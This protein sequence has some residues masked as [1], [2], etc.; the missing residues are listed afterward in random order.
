LVRT[1]GWAFRETWRTMVKELAPQSPDGDYMRPASSIVARKDG[2]LPMLELQDDGH[3]VYIGNTC[4]WCHRVQLAVTLARIPADVVAMV[5]LADDPQRAS[6]GGWAFNPAKGIVDPVFDAADLREVY[7]KASGGRYTGRCTAPL[8]VD[9]INRSAVSNDN[10]EIVRMVTEA[11]LNKKWANKMVDLRPAEL[12]KDIEK[13][14]RWTYNMI[15]N[16]VYRAGFATQQGAFERAAADVAEGLDRLEKLL[17]KQRFLCG[18]KV[19]EADAMLL[20]CALRFDVVYAFLFLRGSCGLWRERPSLKRWL[21]DCWS[22]PGVRGTIDLRACQESY[23]RTLFPLNASQIIPP[24][25]TP[26]KLQPFEGVEEL[27]SEQAEALF[28]WQESPEVVV[29]SA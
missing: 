15:S 7:D 17:D 1:A 14:I 12:G 29:D 10:I 5:E 26:P 25:N 27:T 9:R 23:Y 11:A 18:D 28:H 20:P 19:T 6:R 4:P 21:A 8:L 24:N 13:T 2:K 16:G 22:L 3:A